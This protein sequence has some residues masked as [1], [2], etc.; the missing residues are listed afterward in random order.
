MKGFQVVDWFLWWDEIWNE[1]Q[2]WPP[3]S[4]NKPHSFYI[5]FTCDGHIFLLFT[6]SF[7]PKCMP[8][9]HH[10]T[11]EICKAKG[12]G[13]AEL[14][15]LCQLLQQLPAKGHLDMSC[16]CKAEHFPHALQESS[17]SPCVMVWTSLWLISGF[18]GFLCLTP[19]FHKEPCTMTKQW[20]GISV[21]EMTASNWGRPHS[22][23]HVKWI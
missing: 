1:D 14:L 12:R 4:V 7:P 13:R 23:E 17:S 3:R 10:W 19:G 15:L 6:L 8:I 5:Y 16:C 20:A 2:V 18:A 22:T 21:T 11:L 9:S